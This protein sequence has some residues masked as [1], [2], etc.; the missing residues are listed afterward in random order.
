MD[1]TFLI[2]AAGLGTRMKSKMAK[3]L[4]RAG[5][6]ALLEHVVRAALEVTSPANV[7]VVLGYQAD[8]VRA[9]LERYGVRFAL[10]PEPRGTG[11]AVLCCREAVSDQNGPLV[12]AYG[13]CPLLTSTTF[14]S[15]I[16]QQQRSDQ[17]ATLI[18][19][20]L[21]DPTGYGRVVLDA[22]GNV[23]AIVEQ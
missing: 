18:T 19:T 2:L 15:L 13:D 7:V 10:Q 12:V 8:K 22:Q 3:V 23:E 5:G 16:E 21:D 11:H 17:A 9:A 14:G 4:H 1:P 6:L 20:R